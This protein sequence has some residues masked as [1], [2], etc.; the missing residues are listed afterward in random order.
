VNATRRRNPFFARGEDVEVRR[1][2]GKV[3]GNKELVIYLRAKVVSVSA[4][5]FSYLVQ[6]PAA[7]SVPGRTARVAAFDVRAARRAPPP[8]VDVARPASSKR[9]LPSEQSKRDGGDCCKKAKKMGKGTPEDVLERLIAEHEKEEEAKKK[10]RKSLLP[11][12]AKAAVAGLQ[13][14]R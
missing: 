9:T 1:R 13:P 5:T 14:S 2:L 10:A 3:F 12:P 6:Y 11:A 8:A 4:G 7:N